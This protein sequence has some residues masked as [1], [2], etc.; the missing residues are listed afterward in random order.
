MTPLH[1]CEVRDYFNWQ[2]TTYWDAT[3]Y[4]ETEMAR[5]QCFDREVMTDGLP[6]KFD[7]DCA[8]LGEVKRD[9]VYVDA[10]DYYLGGGIYGWPAGSEKHRGI[11]NEKE[12][13]PYVASPSEAFCKPVPLT[14]MERWKAIGKPVP[15][16]SP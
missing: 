4:H 13:N 16:T 2:C 12:P 5:S 11:W 1:N 15:L 10:V 14:P 3:G 6:D 7:G 9:Y 8:G